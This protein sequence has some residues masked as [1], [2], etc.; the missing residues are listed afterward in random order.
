MLIRLNQQGIF[1]FVCWWHC[2]SVFDRYLQYSVQEILI[3]IMAEQ[4]W[5]SKKRSW[6][7]RM[8]SC[9]WNLIL[10][11]EFQEATEQ[12]PCCRK[13]MVTEYRYYRWY[14]W[15]TLFYFLMMRFSYSSLHTWCW[16][17]D[18]RYWYNTLLLQPDVL[19]SLPDTC[20]QVSKDV[21]TIDN[22][23]RKNI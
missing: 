18:R 5:E 20:S 21:S 6:A 9:W 7:T 17:S 10:V 23:C 14:N 1:D 16:D 12:L 11:K 15:Y 22:G 8:N 4:H 19:I 3:K 2:L 13:A